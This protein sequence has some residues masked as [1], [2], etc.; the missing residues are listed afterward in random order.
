MGFLF[1]GNF[2]SKI[3]VFLLV[4]LYT[5]VLSTTEYGSYDLLYTTVQMLFPILTMNIIDGVMRFSIDETEKNQKKAFTIGLRY[6]LLS[7]LVLTLGIAALSKWTSIRMLQG[8]EIPFLLLYTSYIINNLSNQFARGL[9]D[10]SGI[11]MAG[12]VGTALM[13]GLNIYFLLVIKIGLTGYFYAYII[14]FAGQ[15]M[16]LTVKNK[17][18]KY[19]SLK[20]L[21]GKPT[22]LEK[23]MLRY[24]LP[25]IF[26]TMS[27]HIN[28]LS[29]RYVITFMCGV[30]VNGIYA[31]AHKIPSILNTVQV[32]FIQ[33][34]QL[35]AIKEFGTKAGN[36][37]Y[38]KVYQGCHSIMVILCSVL[39]VGTRIISRLLFAKEFYQAWRF[40]PI[41]LIYIVFN[42]LSGIIGGVF[43]AAKD[44]RALAK[45]A[46]V[47]A[48][49]NLALNFLF[50]YFWGAI[51]AAIATVLSSVI[52]WLMRW[53]YSKKYIRWTVNLKRHYVEYLL[54][55]VQALLMTMFTQVGFY[56]L[57]ILLCAAL[58]GVNIRPVLRMRRKKT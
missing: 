39:I 32:I 25:L 21:I 13:L 28:N 42:T 4:P 26:T 2:T 10:I 49:S 35:S 48:V 41:L 27:W 45:S 20:I 46:I 50:I 43:S 58:V 5:S 24:S 51:G 6:V 22:H 44:T 34:W 12:I 18:W 33:A 19:F 30:A 1:I 40:V 14:S 7:C 16:V 38:N 29:D 56:A 36:A 3:L 11:S 15:A 55:G 9:N 57:Q 31:V 17:F 23:E 53:Q 37:F 47:G 52:I 54:L 8:M